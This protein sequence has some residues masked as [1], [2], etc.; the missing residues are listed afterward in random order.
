MAFGGKVNLG[1]NGMTDALQFYPLI[2]IWPMG[3]DLE[4]RSGSG[5]STQRFSGRPPGG[6]NSPWDGYL[7]AATGEL[8]NPLPADFV[9]LLRIFYASA[10]VNPTSLAG[11]SWVADF[12][13]TAG[14]AIIGGA[15]IV[16]NRVGNRITFTWPD[17]TSNL[18]ILFQTVTLS[19]PPRN[20][21]IFRADWEALLDAG[22]YFNPEY[23]DKVRPASGVVRFMDWQSTNSNRTSRT[24]AEI[25]SI[26]HFNINSVNDPRITGGLPL[27]YIPA[28][29]NKVWSHPW[30]NIPNML[31]TARTGV[32]DSVTAANPPVATST[33]HG[34]SN[35]DI[36]IPYSFS[37]MI[38]SATVTMTI[39]SPCVVS[40]TAHGMPD[41][42]GVRF[43]GGTLPT[44]IIAGNTY[45]VKSGSTDSFNISATPGGAAINTSGSQSGTHTGTQELVR[46]KYTVANKT[47]DTFELSGGNSTGYSAGSA[48][49][50]TSPYSLSSITTE[51]ALYAAHFRDNV[52]PELSTFFE[53]GNEMWNS[54]FDGFH[55]N[56]AQSRAKFANDANNRMQGYLAAHCMKTIRDTYGVGNRS[57][58]KGVL[59]TQTANT[60]VTDEMILGVNQYLTENPGLVFTDLFDYGA[61]TS[62]FNI[63]DGTWYSLANVATSRALIATS[64]QRFVDGLEPTKYAYYDRT[65][66][67]AISVD[68]AYFASQVSKFAA[69][70]LQF[71]AYEGGY[72][73]DLTQL[74]GQVDYATFLEFFAATTKSAEAA[75]AQARMFAAWETFGIYPAKFTDMVPVSRYGS[76]GA[77]AYPG[78]DTPLYREVVSQNDVPK[79][80]RLVVNVV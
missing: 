75:A 53:F 64:T 17:S 40:W 9:S 78:D 63:G 71:I 2:N 52:R 18:Y 11:Q 76:W 41:G 20:I 32:I 47:T 10:E 74:A 12:T 39:A 51:M 59:A 46:N 60:A 8:A 67:A 37:G 54:I 66:N 26:G 5:G 13:G 7:D 34:L 62:Y 58:W 3:H 30:V 61:G 6:T 35:G 80:Y 19:D 14:S 65:V 4:I 27:A 55:W 38:K 56:A 15:S 33:K 57:R 22:E 45:Y 70:G 48:G 68:P 23:I 24:F 25:P 44:G 49:Y 1:L 31:G 16:Q 73:D 29:A 43:G 21:R 69:V 77:L 79:S 28:M 50:Y 42:H 36:I 72:A